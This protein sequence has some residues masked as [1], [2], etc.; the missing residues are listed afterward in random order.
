MYVQ[1]SNFHRHPDLRYTDQEVERVFTLGPMVS[2]RSARIIS[3]H[4]VWSKLYPLE[5]RAGSFKC[6]VRRCQVYSNET[7]TET[8]TC[9]STNQNYKINHEFNCSQSSLFTY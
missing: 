3:N 4:L 6:T 1:L 7:E 8:F 5:R 2:F 9:T